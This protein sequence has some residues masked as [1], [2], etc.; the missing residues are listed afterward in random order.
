MLEAPGAAVLPHADTLLHMPTTSSGYNLTDTTVPF[1][2]MVLSGYL[3]YAA[4]DAGSSGDRE[5]MLL[6]SVEGGS[7]LSFSLMDADYSQVTDTPLDS[8]YAA[9]YAQQRE[10]ILA[11]YARS[12]AALSGVYGRRITGYR[13]LAADQRETVYD[14]GRPFWSITRIS[15]WS[16]GAKR[17]RRAPAPRRRRADG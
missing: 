11:L 8:L 2:Q 6:R 12:R 3:P 9:T 15:R 17:C 7:A 1:L 5:T 16:G 14:D 10:T 13:I 4:E